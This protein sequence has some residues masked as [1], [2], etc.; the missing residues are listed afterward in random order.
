MAGVSGIRFERLV[1]H[2]DDQTRFCYSPG[3]MATDRLA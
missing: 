3:I 1:V 2:S